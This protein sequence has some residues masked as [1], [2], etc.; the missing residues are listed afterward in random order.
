MHYPCSNDIGPDEAFQPTKVPTAETWAAMEKLVD[1]GKVRAIGISNFSRDEIGN[2]LKTCR[3]H[4]A[5]HQYEIHPYLPQ[6]KFLQFHKER[7]ILVVAFT[8]LG[9]QLHELPKPPSVKTIEHPK[10]LGVAA[11]LKKTP[12]QVLVA[13]GLTRGYAVIPKSVTKKRLEE[14]FAG[15]GELLDK[16]DMKT[17]NE[18][19]VR[20]RTDNASE[21]LGYWLY[22]DLDECV[23]PNPFASEK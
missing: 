4:P 7:N 10:V 16:K 2:L 9:Y 5:V 8:P 18:I 17:L 12:A 23:A 1:N 13:W 20:V 11:R 22:S 14:N 19:D 3:I 6:E 15:A 21:P